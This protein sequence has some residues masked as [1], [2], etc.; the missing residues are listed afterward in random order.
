MNIEAL[1]NAGLLLHGNSKEKVG[2]STKNGAEL[3]LN[4]EFSA[5]IEMG[6]LQDDVKQH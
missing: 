1:N 6:E 5:H 4:L 3:D 2:N